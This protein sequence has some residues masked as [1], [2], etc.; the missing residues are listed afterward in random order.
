MTQSVLWVDW[1]P[2]I[3]LIT[4]AEQLEKM[5]RD[6]LLIAGSSINNLLNFSRMFSK[7][8][9]NRQATDFETG[10]RLKVRMLHNAQQM[11]GW[12]TR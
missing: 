2:E 1:R 7:T 4:A 8:K 6:F 3:C 9:I 11:Q 12:A 10:K 5:S